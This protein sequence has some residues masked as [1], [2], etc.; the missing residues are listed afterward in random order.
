[1]DIVDFLKHKGVINQ[2]STDLIISFADKKEVSLVEVFNEFINELNKGLV[3][4]PECK[5]EES[6]EDLTDY[7]RIKSVQNENK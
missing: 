4:C 7:T 6:I 3:I 2:E 5:N 1:M